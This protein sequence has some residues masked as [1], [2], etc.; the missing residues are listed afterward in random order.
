[1]RNLS[2]RTKI[3]CCVLVATLAALAVPLVYAR[4]FLHND[5]LH[6]AKLQ[7]LR[8]AQLAARLVDSLPAGT[9]Q[10]NLEEL[11]TADMRITLLN[12]Y[13]K[14]LA[15]SGVT[16]NHIPDMDNHSDR[17][18]FR[19][20]L[21][22]GQGVSTRYSNT[23]NNDM[24]YATV[25]LRDKNLLRVALPFAGLKSRID[26]KVA[27]MSGVAAVAAAFSLL[28]ALLLSFWLKRELNQ[29]VNVVEAI[30]LGKYQRRLRRLPGREFAVLAEAV[31]RMAQNI[32]EHVHTVADQKEQLESILD[33]MNE[34][35][36]VLGPQGCIR[37]CNRALAQTFPA[38]SGSHGSQVVEV[39]P[40]PA[41]QDAVD[42][43]LSIPRPEAGA[44]ATPFTLQL[45]VPPGRFFDV[46][47]CRARR[48]IPDMGA[49]AV[50]HEITELMRLERIRRDFVANV[51][52]ELRTPL[53]AIQG[54]AE[55]LADME[56]MPADCR[57]FGEIIRKNGIY[58]NRMVEE[59]LSLARLE[60]ENSPLPLTA[61]TLQDVLHSA[62]SL[63]RDQLD[64]KSLRVDI[65]LPEENT[66]H[67]NAP[68]LVQVFRNLLENA[69]RYAPQ[70]SRILVSADAHQDHI[71]VRVCDHGTGIPPTD[72]HRVFERFYRVEKHRNSAGSGA[73][74]GLG[75][76]ICKHIVE[77]HGGH[78][79]AE[80]PVTGSRGSWATA[81]C[82][83]LPLA[84]PS[85]GE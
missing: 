22:D 55:T 3:F 58:L 26:G 23:L 19:A 10:Q 51:S 49:V 83:T 52:H 39:I 73:S 68:S 53:T 21:R 33:T 44:S 29:M 45:E 30:S 79:W 40:L 74:T 17:P 9:A 35:V 13:G 11:G 1:M 54:Y 36:L 64:H 38:A 32:E 77:R 15:D 50:F 43:V 59:L 27:A 67:G 24:V 70:G 66:V 81:L 82:F 63:C 72:L 47:I 69:A 7:A 37:R 71:L 56:D 2:F 12:A 20:A 34:G 75:L 65:D 28:L 84:S 85:P 5:L 42:S 57:R 78:I 8:E 6:D 80:S 16:E 4:V 41:L 48:S 46:H 76:A 18:E 61:L 60:N 14:V 25:K 62:L 31:N